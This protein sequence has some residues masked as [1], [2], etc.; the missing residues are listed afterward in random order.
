M[1]DKGQGGKRERG[2]KLDYT[3]FCNTTHKDDLDIFRSEKLLTT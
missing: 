1:R 2:E 3:I